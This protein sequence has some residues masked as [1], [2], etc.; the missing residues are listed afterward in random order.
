MNFFT[1]LVTSTFDDKSINAFIKEDCNTIYTVD[2]TLTYRIKDDFCYMQKWKRDDDSFLCSLVF[3][4]PKST[5]NPVI[6]HIISE[7]KTTTIRNAVLTDSTFQEQALP[8]SFVDVELCGGFYIGKEI[9]VHTS[10]IADQYTYIEEQGENVMF[11]NSDV[12]ELDTSLLNL[13]D[14]SVLPTGYINTQIEYN[15]KRRYSKKF[16]TSGVWAKVLDQKTITLEMLD[17]NFGA[18]TVLTI[19]TPFVG[20]SEII[21]EDRNCVYPNFISHTYYF[22]IKDCTTSFLPIT[23]KNSKLT[24]SYSDYVSM[25]YDFFTKNTSIDKL[26]LLMSS[27]I[28][29]YKDLLQ[30]ATTK[31]TAIEYIKFEKRNLELI[32]EPLEVKMTILDKLHFDNF[33]EESFF[34]YISENKEKNEMLNC[35]KTILEHYNDNALDR[36]LYLYDVERVFQKYKHQLCLTVLIEDEDIVVENIFITLNSANQISEIHFSS[37]N[38]CETS[39]ANLIFYNHFYS[40]PIPNPSGVAYRPLVPRNYYLQN[41]SLQ[42]LIN[43]TIKPFKDETFN[44]YNVFVNSL[45]EAMKHYTI[46]REETDKAINEFDS[47]TK[48]LRNISTKEFTPF[49]SIFSSHLFEYCFHLGKKLYK[50]SNYIY[51][52]DAIKEAEKIYKDSLKKLDETPFEDDEDIT[53]KMLL[54]D[55]VKDINA[56]K[57]SRDD[58]IEQTGYAMLLYGII[59]EK[60]YSSKKH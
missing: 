24:Y 10:L 51:K 28:K 48:A 2:T 11:I 49:F 56:S 23:Y 54:I 42:Q 3:Y 5:I 8:T 52:L 27:N 50:N 55:L 31:E 15:D 1:K 18:F 7:N 41:Y 47:H 43:A 9:K 20:T 45:F 36:K 30:V 26:A 25:L 57:I 34:A 37:V 19:F 58:A 60:H 12:P 46:D 4:L 32:D 21:L 13:T 29:I 17:K 35:W 38:I 33:D 44:A 53:N 59:K 40:I 39:P 22:H 6:G 16:T 14:S